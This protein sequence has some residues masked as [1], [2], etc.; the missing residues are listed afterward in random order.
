MDKAFGFQTVDLKS[1]PTSI[2]LTLF[3]IYFFFF[4]VFIYLYVLPFVFALGYFLIKLGVLFTKF[5]SVEF[6]CMFSF[7]SL[8]FIS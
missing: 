8:L 4:V 2:L 6:E 7:V 1:K 5:A 3:F